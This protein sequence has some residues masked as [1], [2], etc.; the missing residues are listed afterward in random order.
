MLKQTLN[1]S[2]D[3][4]HFDEAWLPHAA[5]HEFY[6]RHACDRSGTGRGRTMR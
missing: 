2:V 6:K 5:F 3:T 1:N 4:L